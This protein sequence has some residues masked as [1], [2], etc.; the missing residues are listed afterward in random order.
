MDT[1]AGPDVGEDIAWRLEL[2]S[3]RAETLAIFSVAILP[4]T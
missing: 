4:A 1:I 2:P 3:P